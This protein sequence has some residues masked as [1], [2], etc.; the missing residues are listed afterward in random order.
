VTVFKR[1]DINLA[2]LSENFP[3]GVFASALN[4]VIFGVRVWPVLFTRGHL[5]RLPAEELDNALHTPMR[6][7][8][9][10]KDRW[11]FAAWGALYP[12]FDRSKN[13]RDRV[14]AVRWL[15]SQNGSISWLNHA[16]VPADRYLSELRKYRF[17]LSPGGLGVQSPKTFEALLAGVVPV[18]H[19]MNLAY[20]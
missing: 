4:R 8:H 7:L 20:R 12:N 15:Q 1:Y 17:I 10:E 6:Q 14:D 3:N 9:D 2:K 16:K 11:L 19:A 5:R 13:C 18:Y